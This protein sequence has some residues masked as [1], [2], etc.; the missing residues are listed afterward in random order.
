LR[1]RTFGRGVLKGGG[2][3]GPLVL[4]AVPKCPFCLL[5]LVLA[6]GLG[7]PSR[8]ALD[9]FAVAV[10]LLWAAAILVRSP[11]T[12]VVAGA[13]AATTVSLAGRWLEAR[14]LLWMGAAAM[15]ATWLWSLRGS[16]E[17]RGGCSHRGRLIRFD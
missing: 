3:A 4:L 9:T 15:F 6:I 13:I 11:S 2:F 5:P 7:P 1:D 16:R 10:G 14:W 17:C 8:L 12:T